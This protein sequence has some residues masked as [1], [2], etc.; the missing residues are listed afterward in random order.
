MASSGERILIVESDP[1]ISD[2]LARQSLKPLGYETQVVP[3]AATAI[4]QTAQTS[5]DLIIANLSLPGLSGKDLL[6]A[7]TS[8]G[9]RT[10][11]VVIARK[12]EE[13]SVIQ[14]FRLGAVDALFW[15][16]RDAE[17]VRVVERALEQTREART[18]QAL[19]QQ[20][21]ATHSELQRNVR[22]LT[23]ILEI[24][25]AVISMTDQRKL[26]DRILEGAQQL[27]E[28]DLAWLLVRDDRSRS[29][30]LAAQRG[31]PAAWARRINQPLD[32]G[33]G[34]LVA[35]SGEALSIH[36]APLEKFKVAALGKSAAVLPMKVQ[37]EVIGLLMVARKA[38]REIDKAALTLLE[39]AADFGSISLVQARLFRAIAQSKEAARSNEKIRT[40]MLESA[41]ESIREE[42]QGAMSRLETLLSGKQGPLTKEQQDA[43]KDIRSSMQ[44]LAHSAETTIPAD[45]MRPS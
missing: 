14:A 19:G 13:Q 38:D 41:R 24:G 1:D 22:E 20:L 26:F 4:Q 11:V 10:P 23:V 18:R 45:P 44:R 34:A 36:G 40:G 39:A 28:A 2:L 43:L 5:P 15:P 16:A 3:D 12:G 7:L 35:L 17:V 33:I 37:K 42:T 8:Q 30:L 32:D 25:R 6:T 29:Y 27:A 21:E 31:L 9:L